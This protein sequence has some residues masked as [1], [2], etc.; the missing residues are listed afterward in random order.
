MFA[1]RW[2]TSCLHGGVENYLEREE[3]RRSIMLDESMMGGKEK[4]GSGG[5][6]GKQ[7]EVCDDRDR[8]KLDRDTTETGMPHTCPCNIR[9][10]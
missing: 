4:G 7:I 3:K 10:A 8:A 2:R 6:S 9:K 5:Q 1:A